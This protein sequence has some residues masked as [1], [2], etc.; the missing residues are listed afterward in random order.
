MY[1]CCCCGVACDCRT[2]IDADAHTD[3]I[4][5]LCWAYNGTCIITGSRDNDMK[6]WCS[7]DRIVPALSLSLCSFHRFLPLHSRPRSYLRWL[8]RTAGWGSSMVHVLAIVAES[9]PEL[10]AQEETHLLLGALVARCGTQCLNRV[11]RLSSGAW[12]R[13]SATRRQCSV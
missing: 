8:V 2:D 4:D 1:C 3:A 6:V 12:K 11:T 7:I 10:E 9:L 5:S 13:F